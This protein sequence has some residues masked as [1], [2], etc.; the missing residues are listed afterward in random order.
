VS[1]NAEG[2]RKLR[3]K[4]QQHLTGGKTVSD[5][6][7]AIVRRAN[8]QSPPPTGFVSCEVMSYAK[9]TVVHRFNSAFAAEAHALFL[10][11]LNVPASISNSDPESV[12]QVVP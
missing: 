12:I 11:T 8:M 9:R 7:D 5:D 10:Q 4:N 6:I 1:D 3:L 2:G